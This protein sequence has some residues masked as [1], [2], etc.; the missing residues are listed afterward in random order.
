MEDIYRENKDDLFGTYRK[1][2][3]EPNVIVSVTSF[4]DRI[5]KASA[6]L[7]TLLNQSIKPYKTILWLSEDEFPNL[8]LDLPPDLLALKEQGLEIM[9]DQGNRKSF[10]KLLPALEKYPDC[11]IVTAD[12]DLLYH[13]DWLFSLCR[14][15]LTDRQNVH[16][17]RVTRLFFYDSDNVTEANASEKLRFVPQNL[18]FIG[19]GYRA[20]IKL[21]SSFNKPCTGSGCLFPPKTFDSTVFNEKLYQSLCP[22]SDDIW[23]YLCALRKKKKVRVPEISFSTLSYVEGTQ[24]CALCSS[25]DKFHHKT[26]FNHLTNVFNLFKKEIFPFFLLDNTS[27]SFIV[28]EIYLEY[29]CSIANKLRNN[30]HTRTGDRLSLSNPLKFSEK[31]QWSKLFDSTGYKSTLTD[32]LAVRKYV[33]EK[34]GKEYLIPILGVYECP[35]DIDFSKLPVPSV[36]KCNHGCGFNIILKPGEKV[37]VEEIKQKLSKWMNINFSFSNNF[38]LHYYPI[39]PRIYVEKYIENTGDHDVFDYKFWCFNGK[40]KFIQFLSERNTNGLKMLFLT[41]EW[42]PTDYVYD[43]SRL[44]FLKAKKPKNLS[45]MIGIAEKLSFGFNHVRVDL[46]NIS[47]KIYFGELTF[48]SASGLMNWS[49]EGFDF[50]LGKEFKL[51]VLKFNCLTGKNFSEPAVKKIASGLETYSGR[52]KIFAVSKNM[53]KQACPPIIWSFAKRLYFYLIK[54][55]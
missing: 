49:S 39:K 42:K 26:F 13:H 6:S 34:I 17:H 19:P 20:D 14:S 11:I 21:P 9:W 37:N 1:M 43:H 25:N 5:K 10:K 22:S 52:K 12:D 16:C 33:E 41:P 47:E 18:L 4:P 48:T 2:L 40:V 28:D 24:D 45:K 30:Y 44:D 8:E 54:T 3:D 51:P 35:E 29:F 38:E 36:I 46:Y 50:E 15:Y 31:I 7:V 55:R 53:I 23:F 32:K 27:N